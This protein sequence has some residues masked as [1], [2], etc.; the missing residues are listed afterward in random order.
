[1]G[2]GSVPL[3]EVCPDIITDTCSLL[4]HRFYT[5]S[6]LV[7]I[8]A[9][10]GCLPSQITQDH[11]SKGNEGLVKSLSYYCCNYLYS[12]LKHGITKVFQTRLSQLCSCKLNLNIT[13]VNCSCQQTPSFGCSP[14]MN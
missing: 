8:S 4:Y 7:C 13:V 14:I 10:L 2:L 12:Y 1:M 11:C 3:A 9:G 5:L 6:S